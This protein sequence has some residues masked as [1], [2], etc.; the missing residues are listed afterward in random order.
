LDIAPLAPF[1]APLLLLAAA[2]VIALLGLRHLRSLN[3][4]FPQAR[5]THRALRILDQAIVLGLVGGA[6]ALAATSGYNA[7]ALSRFRALRTPPGQLY[8]VNGRQMHLNC[9]GPSQSDPAA[10]T[11]LLDSGLGNDSLIW[12][13]V[14]PQL[15]RTTRVC[16]YDRAGFGWSQP[17]PGPRDADHIAADL[18]QLLAQANIQ[19]PL[20]LMG[21]S[22]AGIYI[23]DYAARYPAQ[24]AGLIFVDGST[25]L[26][27]QN[28]AFR[29][30]GETG[31][32][33]LTSILVMGSANLAGLPRLAGICARTYP[34]FSPQAARLLSEDLCDL[35][36]DAIQRE[37]SSF[38]AS[39]LETLKQEVALKQETVGQQ[40]AQAQ[41]STRQN[42]QASP[43]GSLPILIFSQDP[44]RVLAQKH[45]PRAM[46]N[47][48][49]EWSQLQ[50][51]LKALSTN[52]RRIVARGS[53]HSV[54]LDRPDLLN[55]EVPL[56]INQIRGQAPQPDN[57]GQT[58]TE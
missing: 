30:A 7:I 44:A 23:R 34:G 14:Q 8:L 35:H 13:A 2:T 55:K 46:L 48:E 15:A 9:T 38:H 12:G 27:D 5:F 19:G 3:A 31:S 39:G 45:A 4:R 51:N 57:Y 26:Q 25:P 22:I 43:F 53:S 32:A 6:L 36:Y 54:Q 37:L 11:I 41:D 42:R 33:R 16:S 47:L 52:S 24:V 40:G 29:Q 10:P 49:R 18:H 21:H 50:E 58:I 17:Q 1:A 28:P 56:F 20:I